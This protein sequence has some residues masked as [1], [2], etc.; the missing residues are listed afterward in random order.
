MNKIDAQRLKEVLTIPVIWYRL[1]LPGQPSRS[2]RSPFREDKKP[3][4]SVY[5]DGMRWKDF[6]TGEG[7]DVI[8]FL[9]KAENNS[10]KEAFKRFLKIAKEYGYDN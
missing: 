3:S 9:A 4:F 6:S 10:P 2:C 1:A 8:D 5:D 7:G